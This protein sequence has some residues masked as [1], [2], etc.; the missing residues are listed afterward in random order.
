MLRLTFQAIHRW[1]KRRVESLAKNVGTKLKKGQLDDPMTAIYARISGVSRPMKR[2]QP[3]QQYQVENRDVVAAEIKRQFQFGLISGSTDK[4]DGAFR[5]KVV[6]GMFDK[7]SDE[8][9][10]GY[11]T[12]AK[13]EADEEKQMWDEAI[14]GPSTKDPETRAK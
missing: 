1:L 3:A 13:A 14:N 7:L 5:Q 4:L 8:E 11:A 2:R 10:D 9:K 6:R 12:R